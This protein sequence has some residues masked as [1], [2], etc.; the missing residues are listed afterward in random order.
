M[1]IPS[2][3]Y[4][5]THFVL[6]EDE[7][8]YFRSNQGLPIP[9][10]QELDQSPSTLEIEEGNQGVTAS[11]EMEFKH[12]F[13]RGQRYYTTGLFTLMAV[14]L[15]ADQNLLAPNL[16]AAAA[17][18]N[19][20]ETQKDIFLGGYISAAF[21]AV[22]A[23]AAL[24]VGWYT[25]KVNRRNLLFA[26]AIFGQAPNMCTIFVT[27]YW[28]FFV[29]RLLTGISVGG[30]FPLLY[31][32][33][34][35]LFPIS[36]RAM[37]SAFILIATGAG[38][39]VG[40]ML[41][42]L[43]GPAAGW[44]L[45]FVI[46]SV[47]A[48]M[49]ACVM[50]LT[51]QEPPRGVCEEALQGRQGADGEVLTYNERISW[52]KVKLLMRVPSNWLIVM[53]G[54][55]G[56][57]PWGMFMTFLNDFFQTRHGVSTGVATTIISVFGVG[58][59]IGV[60]AGG[61]LIQHLYNKKKEYMPMLAG[62]CVLLGVGPAMYLVNGPVGSQLGWSFFMA[63]VD[64][65]LAS[66]AGPCVKAAIINVNDPEVRGV[67]LALQSMTDDLGKALGPFIV[68]L[69]ITALGSQE[70]AF[71]LAICSW[72]PCG[73]L[74]LLL[75][76]CMRR[77]EDEV[78]A[79]LVENTREYSQVPTQEDGASN[80]DASMCNNGADAESSRGATGEAAQTLMEG[81]GGI[82]TTRGSASYQRLPSLISALPSGQHTDGS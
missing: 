4:I 2:G 47:P 55:P 54:L 31:S 40:Q 61:W 39:F 76:F 24:L 80:A 19:M 15:F 56:S 59:G 60:V 82:F 51:T 57:L 78:Q 17:F 37:V 49:V 69:F 36:Q 22:G 68:A 43:I 11:L 20:S 79:R 13:S 8:S 44:R 34:G 21:F 45:P 28:Q 62:C 70:R 67:A 23:P 81:L 32:L 42:G 46:I 71:N 10:S 3:Q 72:I 75:V 7:S 29:L 16:S 63:F 50:Q 26:V 38:V 77:D 6:S 52:A 65:V 53:Q 14:L 27:E 12:P 66:V 9:S 73:M 30:V 5:N 35:D 74:I 48:I 25:D 64:G 33:L 58:G 41:A 18:F 1:T